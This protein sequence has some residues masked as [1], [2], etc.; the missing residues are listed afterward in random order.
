MAQSMDTV[1]SHHYPI[2]ERKSVIVS[3]LP[4]HQPYQPPKQSYVES[5]PEQ[6]ETTSRSNNS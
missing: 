1:I 3:E 2:K 6:T 5:Y 4:N